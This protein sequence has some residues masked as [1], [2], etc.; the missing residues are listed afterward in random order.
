MAF[1]YST[2]AIAKAG[3]EANKTKVIS[4]PVTKAKT[5]P[6]IKVPM[7]IINVDIFYPIAP[8]NANVSFANF[9][10]NSVWFI[11]SNHP[12]YCFNKLLKY[13]FLHEIACLSPEIIQHA[14]M[15]HPAPKTPIPIHK[16]VNKVFFDAYTISCLAKASVICP[17]IYE[18]DGKATPIPKAA[19]DPITINNISNFVANLNI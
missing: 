5:N 18:K 2:P 12:I 4:Q 1:I 9:D 10:A 17:Q 3:I 8:W 7:V 6:D 11:R 15:S 13:A 19:I 14:N 16:K